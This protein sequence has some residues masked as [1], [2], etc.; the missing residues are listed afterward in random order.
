MTP[1]IMVIFGATGDLAQ[2]KLIPSL[3]ALFK[4]N[5]LSEAFSI[6]G[7]SRRDFAI[8]DFHK[9]FE[10]AKEDPKWSDF[11]KHLLYQSG[12]FEDISAYQNLGKQL[13]AIDNKTDDCPT[14]FFYLATPPEHYET[15]LDNL[16]KTKL[17]GNCEVNDENWTRI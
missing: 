12:S 10:D 4:E 14:R 7:F 5:L 17:S 8:E 11:A 16:V 6:V 15:I 3:F 1:F 13:E 9:Y 2:N